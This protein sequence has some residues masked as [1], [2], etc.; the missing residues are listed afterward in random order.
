MKKKILI[1]SDIAV[2]PPT[3]GN[4]SRVWALM[5]NLRNLGHEVW[6]FGLG[7]SE[8]AIADLRKVWGND[9]VHYCPKAR[10][11]SL[12][13]FWFAPVRYCSIRLVERGLW[14]P[15]VD[16]YYWSNW[17][18]ALKEFAATHAFDVVMVEY[19][20]FSKALENFPGSVRKII[21]AHD[22]YTG[23]REKLLARNSFAG[24]YVGSE[25]EEIRGL[26]RADVVI[27]IQ[28]NESKIF[29]KMLGP[30][31]RVV[32]VG[33]TVK[34]QPVPRPTGLEIVFL[35][36]AYAVNVD[37]VRHFIDQC[38]PRIRAAIPE[39]KL[40]IAG[41]ICKALKLSDDGVELLG[42]VDEVREAYQRASVVINPVLTGTG[43][44][45]KTIEALA[46][47]RPLVTTSW[48]ADGLREG[49]GS[50]FYMADDPSEFADRVITLLTHPKEAE[51]MGQNGLRFVERWNDE[52][53]K[54]LDRTIA[55][56]S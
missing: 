8:K 12:R 51:K 37:G 44:K 55:E 46:F 4:R 39:A 1:I 45:T 21:D 30:D 53:L 33:H 16:H 7:T 19:V 10:L 34:L 27:G 52:Q 54:A 41:L 9:H 2:Y 18:E 47:G 24:R 25:R 40:V 43:L 31:K 35:G 48:G 13:P 3:S 50:A 56:A 28:E 22:V 32:T 49:A 20:F 17:D 14:P 26:N 38:L 5:N 11:R 15:S 42:E 23:R 6:F 36:S 29:R